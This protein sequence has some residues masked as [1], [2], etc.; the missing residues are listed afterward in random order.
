MGNIFSIEDDVE[1]EKVIEEPQAVIPKE[2]RKVERR[3][4]TSRSKSAKRK[5]HQNHHAKT[6]S[7]NRRN[8]HN[9]NQS[10]ILYQSDY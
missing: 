6:Y 2:E 10:N 7:K 1:R 3:K 8:S 9:H 4:T 5:S